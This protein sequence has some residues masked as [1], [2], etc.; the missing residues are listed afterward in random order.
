MNN[1]QTTVLICPLD[2]GLGHASRII[3]VVYLFKTSGY[4]VILGGSGK[5]GKLLKS[6]FSDIPFIRISSLAIHYPFRGRWF[7][8]NI[9]LQ[10]PVI[11][12]NYVKEHYVLK[13][14][15]NAY[16]INFV[17]SDNRYGLYSN[18]TRNII[19]THQ[20]SPVLPHL[21]LW[22]EYPLYLFVKA[23]IHHFDECWIPDLPG[24]NNL[25]GNLSHR[26]PIP[27]N[28]IFIG[29][30]SR[31]MVFQ[32]GDEGERFDL[33]IVLS[34]PQPELGRITQKIFQQALNS[35]ITALII[36]GFQDL[37]KFSA[38][39]HGL[40]VVSHLE[41]FKFRTILEKASAIICSAGFSG[42]M[43]LITIGKSAILI[44]AKGQT[45]QEYLSQYLHKQ[46]FFVR[47]PEPEF[48][49]KNMSDYLNQLKSCK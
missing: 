26:Y 19:I 1:N 6:T 31:F 47:I 42:I 46:G 45:E 24:K 10:L 35:E 15:V 17:I 38:T 5:S 13:S 21:L 27:R 49:L 29:P 41:P 20:I 2:W 30:L 7:A 36:C 33:V 11:I 44:P 4:K 32:G 3:P 18:K 16:N 8:L 39:R 14:L 28:A 9:I 22:L 12:Y 48:D 23:L 40:K 25:S 34:G 37:N 43:D